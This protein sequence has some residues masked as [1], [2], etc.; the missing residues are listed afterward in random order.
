[1][2]ETL[3]FS[4]ASEPDSD[5]DN[6][7]AEAN[8]VSICATPVCNC[9]FFRKWQLPCQHIWHADMAFH[10]LTDAAMETWKWGWE[11]GGFE[12]YE[13]WTTDW[14]ESR[15]MEE[16]G[17]PLRYRLNLREVTDSIQS[18]FFDLEQR[19]AKSKRHEASNIMG[20]WLDKLN[21]MAQGFLALEWGVERNDDGG[22]QA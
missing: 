21:D 14:V 1:M 11:E 8:T 12:M 18:R 4:H 17:A 20:L 9:L 2:K 7:T 16:I 5:Y 22:N 6:S 13:H 19:L 3:Q 15:V 10:I